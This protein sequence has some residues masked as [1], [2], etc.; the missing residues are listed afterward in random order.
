MADN[1][2]SEN[3]R[4][5]ISER[6]SSESPE[7]ITDNKVKDQSVNKSVS[8]T[9]DDITKLKDIGKHS[10]SLVCSTI[11]NNK[12]NDIRSSI[13]V[14]P[15][16]PKVEIKMGTTDYNSKKYIVFIELTGE[17]IDVN[18]VSKFLKSKIEN[19]YNKKKADLNTSLKAMRKNFEKIP[20]NIKKALE[21]FRKNNS[22][23]KELIENPSY[24]ISNVV[25]SAFVNILTAYQAEINDYIDE[26]KATIIDE[27]KRIK[28]EGSNILVGY[29]NINTH[30]NNKL[31]QIPYLFKLYRVVGDGNLKDNELCIF[32]KNGIK[33]PIE[34]VKKVVIQNDFFNCKK[35]T[36]NVENCDDLY[37][38]LYCDDNGEKPIDINDV[39]FIDYKH[40]MNHC[41]DKYTKEINVNEV[42]IRNEI[43]RGKSGNIISSRPK[44]DATGGYSDDEDLSATSAFDEDILENMNG[45]GN[46]FSATSYSEQSIFDSNNMYNKY[47]GN[48]DNLSISQFSA[49]SSLANPSKNQYGGNNMIETN[50][51][52]GSIHMSQLSATS[53]L[54][55]QEKDK[56]QYGG[57]NLSETSQYDDSI[58]MSQLS[59][60]SSINQNKNKMDKYGGNKYGGNKYGSNNM[61]ETSSYDDSIH[62]SQLS[63]TSSINHNKYNRQYGGNNM[64]ETSPYDGPINMSQFSETSTINQN[65]NQYGGNNMS[66]TSPYDGSINMSQFS[67]TSTINQNKNQCGGNNM[68]D[69]SPYDGSINISQ[70]SE[71]SSMNNNGNRYGYNNMSDT[72]S[73][74]GSIHMSQFSETSSDNKYSNKNRNEFKSFS[75]F[76]NHSYM[77]HNLQKNINKYNLSDSNVMS[78]S[79]NSNTSECNQTNIL[80]K[81]EYNM[82]DLLKLGSMYI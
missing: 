79:Q 66:D 61:S 13:K 35:R 80:F 54:M 16:V 46:I 33:G 76:V 27:I 64:S 59:A 12:K 47:G 37:Y 29:V 28:T 57:N 43:G 17:N 56:T 49:T 71:T 9:F 45:G 67:E 23:I 82:D 21:E 48:D 58:H 6:D 42:N 4:T 18:N 52:D 72:S 62:L 36:E 10:F 25:E 75:P 24:E 55:N 53:S 26:T 68:S 20:E 77:S 51:Y 19:A 7:P 78:L 74:N 32:D 30:D 14:D 15:I 8:I 2:N 38:Y 1:D 44:F 3:T 60:T 11:G 41:I 65:K 40:I 39:L 63:A 70:F 73:F 50:H 31:D 69:T 81:K 5:G 34:R 22:T